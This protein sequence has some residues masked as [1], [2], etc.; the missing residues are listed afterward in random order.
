MIRLDLGCGHINDAHFNQPLRAFHAACAECQVLSTH[1]LPKECRSHRVFD[2]T[3][4]RGS[5]FLPPSTE[6]FWFAK[7]WVSDCACMPASESVKKDLC[8]FFESPGTFSWAA[9]PA[10]DAGVWYGELDV[11]TLLVCT[12][13][14][15]SANMPR[16][17]CQGGLGNAGPVSLNTPTLRTV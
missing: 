13:S 8:R 11:V 4:F 5:G 17:F 3:K 12:A 10:H 2:T 7:G 9:A 16:D 14:C 15:S 6:S 1:Y